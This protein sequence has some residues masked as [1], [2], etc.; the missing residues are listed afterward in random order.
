MLG[1]SEQG[2]VWLCREHLAGCWHPVC[3]QSERADAPLP[4]VTHQVIMSTAVWGAARVRFRVEKSPK[5]GQC[6]LEPVVRVLRAGTPGL[7]WEAQLATPPCE[8][9]GTDI[10]CLFPE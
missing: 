4:R 2:Q 7:Q 5:R 1:Q 3:L 8:A 10:H 6:L 9:S